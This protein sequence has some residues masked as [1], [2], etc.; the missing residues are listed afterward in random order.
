MENIN[1][2]L[3]KVFGKGLE[4]LEDICREQD[5]ELSEDAVASAESYQSDDGIASECSCLILWKG[6]PLM[7]SYRQRH[8]W[9]ELDLLQRICQR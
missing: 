7:F 3:E 5:I 8:L 1:P 4:S 9:L 2:L 6:G